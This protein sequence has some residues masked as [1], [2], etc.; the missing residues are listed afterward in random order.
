MTLYRQS[1]GVEEDVR[2]YSEM[3]LVK[4]RELYPLLAMRVPL[5]LKGKIYKTCVQSML[6]YG[7]GTWD[8][9]VEDMNKLE[10]KERSMM[11]M[12]HDVNTSDRKSSKEIVS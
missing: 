9:K 5:N 7:S 3:G 12:M 10:R 6:S 8:M 1:G 2:K 11:R 4:F